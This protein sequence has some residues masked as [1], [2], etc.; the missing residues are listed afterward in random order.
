MDLSKF[1]TE[2]LKN[3]LKN[4]NDWLQQSRSLVSKPGGWML[5]DGDRE[6]KVEKM[7]KEI[8]LEIEKRTSP[9]VPS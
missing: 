1:D 2:T 7:A 5:W 9:Q 4:A 8:S 3:E 6:E